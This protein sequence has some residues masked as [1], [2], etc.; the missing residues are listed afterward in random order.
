MKQ[1]TVILTC[2]LFVWLGAGRAFAEPIDDLIEDLRDPDPET[3]SEAALALAT[4]RVDAQDRQRLLAALADALTTTDVRTRRLAAFALS[5]QVAASES[6]PPRLVP[7][8]V[9]GL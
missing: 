1:L 9:G 8:L 7:R 3:R 4:A 5:Q 6:L 2:L